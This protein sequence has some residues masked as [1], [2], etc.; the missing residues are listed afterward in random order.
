MSINFISMIQC[1]DIL[2]SIKVFLDK[3]N[4]SYVKI[5]MF[6]VLYFFK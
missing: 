4:K 5:G 1:L 6:T 2:D 3:A